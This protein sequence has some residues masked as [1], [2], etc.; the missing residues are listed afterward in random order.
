MASNDIPA[1]LFPDMP[2]DDRIADENGVLTHSWDSGLSALFSALQTNFSNQ[3]ILFPSLSQDNI[4]I[5]EDSFAPYIGKNLPVG[6][7]DISGLTVF[8]SDNRV[9]KQFVITYAANVI[10]TAGW[11]TLQYV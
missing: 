5:I 10:A 11:R 7:I 4:T 8:D 1:A 2:S 3:G 9:S 6:V